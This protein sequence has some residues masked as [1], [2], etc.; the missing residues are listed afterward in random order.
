MGHTTYQEAKRRP[1][2]KSGHHSNAL[3]LSWAYITC[4]GLPSA[5]PPPSSLYSPFLPEPQ[6]SH[7]EP[8]STTLHRDVRTSNE[9]CCEY[10]PNCLSNLESKM[11]NLDH[12]QSWRCSG[13]R[14][15]DT[16]RLTRRYGAS[17][18]SRTGTPRRRYFARS[19]LA[20]RTVWLGIR[21]M[22]GARLF[23]FSEEKLLDVPG[24]RGTADGSAHYVLGSR[25]RHFRHST[26]A[27]TVRGTASRY[28]LRGRELKSFRFLCS[29]RPHAGAEAR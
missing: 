8:F 28:S 22:T 19:V 4:C 3:A 12:S 21:V 18:S 20:S 29:I 1:A 27:E 24:D 25:G 16:R 26:T 10:S 11:L 9:I 7:I 6:A 17:A 5:V 14:G 23:T 2:R 15:A 13:A